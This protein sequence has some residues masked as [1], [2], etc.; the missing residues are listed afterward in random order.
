MARLKKLGL[1]FKTSTKNRAPRETGVVLSGGGSRASFQLGALN[2]LYDKT[3]F[4]PTV[5]VGTSAGAIVSSMLAQFPERADQAAGVRKLEALWRDLNEQSDMFIERLWFAKLRE[6]TSELLA[7]LNSEPKPTPT[8]TSGPLP[9]LLRREEPT[10]PVLDGQPDPLTIALAPEEP[11]KTEWSPAIFSQILGNLGKLGRAGSDLPGIWQS[12][13]RTRAAYRAGPLLARLLEPDVFTGDRV[14]K[15]GLKLRMAMVGLATG[16]LRFM[17]EDGRI[18][19]RNDELIDD[20]PYDL[21]LG[22]LASCAIPAVFAPVPL[23]DETYVDGGVRENLPAEMAISHLDTHPTWVITSAPP[24]VHTEPSARDADVMSVMMRAMN[25]LTDESIRDEVAYAKAAGAIV[26][27]PELNIHDPLTVDRE[28]IAINIDYGWT[29]AAEVTLGMDASVQATHRRVFELRTSLATSSDEPEQ[30][31]ADRLA[32]IRELQTAI[33][34]SS[35]DALPAEARTW[36]DRY[37]SS[38]MTMAH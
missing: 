25:I 28:L 8:R 14:S 5:F 20:T 12:A 33:D 34:E 31:P 9:R 4:S 36:P 35:P 7:A 13:D 23:G 32:T 1:P 11:V 6:H 27:E 24:G 29:R 21:A 26:I 3:D 37:A 16:E 30:D 15:A 38:A 18:V 19:D 2:Y 17:R 22:V 10:L